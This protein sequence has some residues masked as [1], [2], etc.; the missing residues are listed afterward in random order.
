MYNPQ[1]MSEVHFL[2]ADSANTWYEKS[3]VVNMSLCCLTSSLYTQV[4]KLFSNYS[5]SQ[6]C[7]NEATH[8]PVCHVYYFCQANICLSLQSHTHLT[9]LPSWWA[10]RSPCGHCVHS[11]AGTR[12]TL[13]APEC[14]V[15][16]WSLGGRSRQRPRSPH[17]QS[18]P[19]SWSLDPGSCRI[20]CRSL[21]SS[22]WSI[23]PHRTQSVFC[24]KI[25]NFFLLTDS[26]VVAKMLPKRLFVANTEP[27]IAE[28][29][30]QT[31]HC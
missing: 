11:S 29:I 8:M 1:S 15:G 26:R 30:F 18:W 5:H 4:N 14:T 2:S 31:C 9:L 23:F 10:C 13:R 7:I 21:A 3:Q 6:M 19:C 25:K 28:N 20:H 12:G 16:P 22:Q 17:G 24:H 27:Q